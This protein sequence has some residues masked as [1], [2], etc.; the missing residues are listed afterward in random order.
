MGVLPA[1]SILYWMVTQRSVQQLQTR[2]CYLEGKG[3][4]NFHWLENNPALVFPD[5]LHVQAYDTGE[6]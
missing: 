5:T 6:L 3:L 2:C 4:W 1:L